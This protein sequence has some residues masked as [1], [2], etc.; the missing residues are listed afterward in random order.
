MNG[1]A[2]SLDIENAISVCE[3]IVL[4][5]TNVGSHNR[6]PTTVGANSGQQLDILIRQVFYFIYLVDSSHFTGMC[7]ALEFDDQFALLPSSVRLSHGCP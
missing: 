2:S 5:A 6:M 3:N 7:E 4:P 1:S